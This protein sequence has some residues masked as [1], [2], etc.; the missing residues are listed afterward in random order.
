MIPRSFIPAIVL[1]S[2]SS[3]FIMLANAVLYAIVGEVNRKLTDDQQIGYFVW[4]PAKT[5]RVFREYRRLYPD[6][7]LS[8]YYKLWLGLGLT[9]LLGCAWQIGIFR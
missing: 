1:L 4:Y 9:A 5:L 8:L 6:G 7:R 2:I 3:V